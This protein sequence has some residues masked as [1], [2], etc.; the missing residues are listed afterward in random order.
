MSD[1][2]QMLKQERVKQVIRRSNFL[3]RTAE[4]WNR[5]PRKVLQPPSVEIFEM[6][7]EKSLSNTVWPYSWLWLTK[8][9][10]DALYMVY[11]CSFPL[12]REDEKP[13]AVGFSLLPLPPAEGDITTG[14]TTRTQWGSICLLAVSLHR[15]AL[16]FS[17]HI[18]LEKPL[19]FWFKHSC[20]H[21]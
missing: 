15:R 20:F 17:F 9:V 11:L 2:R 7:L 3:R 8:V 14:I 12:Q 13:T 6:Q 1:N 19:S 18:Y 10:C 5:F 4:L 21:H 16:V